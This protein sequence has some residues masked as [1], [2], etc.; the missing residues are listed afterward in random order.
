ML[1]ESVAPS[2]REM[3]AADL[4]ALVVFVSDGLLKV[5]RRGVNHLRGS[6][7]FSVAGRLPPELQMRLCCISSGYQGDTVSSA[8]S[9][10]ALRDRAYKEKI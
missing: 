10:K 9:Q 1:L 7:F 8:A 6:K 2:R 3:Q 5:R 4:F